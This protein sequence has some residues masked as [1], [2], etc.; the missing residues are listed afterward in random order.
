[1]IIMAAALGNR[2]HKVIPSII[3]DNQV[4]YVK[5][6]MSGFNIRLTQYIFEYMHRKKEGCCNDDRL[7]TGI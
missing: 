5:K 6:R 3:H 7:S 1:M 4:G 2:L